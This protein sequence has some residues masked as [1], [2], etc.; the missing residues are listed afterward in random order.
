MIMTK[1]VTCSICKRKFGNIG[2]LSKHRSKKHPRSAKRKFT[3]V[4][5]AGGRTAANKKL[6]KEMQ[7]Y[8][9]QKPK[10]IVIDF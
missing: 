10:R 1:R 7:S 5:I 3:K 2:L 9:G 6:A 4:H 8:F